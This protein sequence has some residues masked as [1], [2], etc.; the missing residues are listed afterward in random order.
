MIDLT[1][2][3]WW[4]VLNAIKPI[5][6]Y[7]I[8][9]VVYAVFI[10]KFYRFVARRNILTLDLSAYNYAQHAFF[11]KIVHF[12][13]YCI[14]YLLVMPILV[15]FWFLVLTALL[16]FLAENQP[17]GQVMLTAMALVGAVRVTSYYSEDLSRDLAKMLPFALL[18]VY[19]IKANAFSFSESVTVLKGLPSLWETAIAYLVFIISLEVVMR[20]LHLMVPRRGRELEEALAPKD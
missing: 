11:K 13:L 6:L 18:G 8:G 17:L 20:I 14:A 1:Y 2:V 9:M 7:I 12:F 4:E 10:F 5:A 16:V 3:D 19:I 15:F